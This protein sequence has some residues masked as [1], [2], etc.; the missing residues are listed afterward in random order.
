MP[1]Y[2]EL[3]KQIC[4]TSY[5]HRM[6]DGSIYK[7][8]VGDDDEAMTAIAKTVYTWASKL[9]SYNEMI[10]KLGEL[11]AKVK[12]YESI[13]VN[14]NFAPMVINKNEGGNS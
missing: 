3:I 5:D 4:I 14:S 11:E 13:I 12:V 10:Q 8:S 2:E 7:R 1:D 9:I 6:Y